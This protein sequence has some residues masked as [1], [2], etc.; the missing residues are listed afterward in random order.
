MA[1]TSLRW[2]LTIYLQV[3]QLLYMPGQIQ[4]HLDLACS[5]NLHSQAKNINNN[6]EFLFVTWYYRHAL[7]STCLA[8]SSCNLRSPSCC[9][10]SAALLSE[11]PVAVD[12]AVEFM[13]LWCCLS[14]SNIA[15]K[16]S[17]INS[18]SSSCWSTCVITARISRNA[19]K[20]ILSYSCIRYLFVELFFILHP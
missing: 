1:P 19:N 13:F 20:F 2:L 17:S 8:R 10:S 15:S 16:H 14:S 7:I 4:P 18:S 6:K 12:H 5:R 9:D 11:T 3:S